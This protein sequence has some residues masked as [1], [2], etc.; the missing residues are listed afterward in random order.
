MKIGDY[1]ILTKKIDKVFGGNHPNLI[2]VG[3]KEI[4][5][6]LKELPVI[7]EQLCLFQNEKMSS[8]SAWTSEVLKFDDKTIETK[9]SIYAI[10]IK[11]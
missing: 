5:G 11:K 7:G 9:N 10:K 8:M 3:S 1:V 2:N 4:Q 6:Y